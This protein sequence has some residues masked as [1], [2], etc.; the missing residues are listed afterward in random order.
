MKDLSLILNTPVKF[1]PPTGPDTEWPPVEEWQDQHWVWWIKGHNAYPF[2]T[3]YTD[4]Q[5]I[6]YLRRDRYTYGFGLAKRGSNRKEYFYLPNPVAVPFH[7]AKVPNILFGGAAG[8]SKSY[9]QRYDAYRHCAT[10]PEFKAIIMRRTMAELRRNHLDDARRECE[11]INHF[12]GEEMMEFRVNDAEIVFN[13]HGPGRQSKL[14]FGHCQHVGDEEQYLGDA[15]EAFY[16]DEMATFEQKQII[17]VSGRLRTKKRRIVPRMAGSSNPGGAHTSWLRDYFIDKPLATILDQNPKYKPEKYLFIQAM[18]WDNPY[19]MDPD[20]TY[21]TYEERL[22]AYDPERRLQLLLGDWDALSGQFFPEFN[23][24]KHVRKLPMPPGCRIERWIDWGY[25]PDYGICVWVCCL[26]NGRLHVFFEWKFNGA[27]SRQKYTVGEAAHKIKEYTTTFALPWAQAQ[28]ITRS[29]ADPSMWG[30]EQHIGE[31]YAET[32]A[33]NGVPLIKADS[34]R[35]MGWGRLRHWLRD[36]PDGLP[37]LTIDPECVNTV[38]SFT[39]AVRDGS[40]SDDVD[41]RCEDH[42]IDVCRYG[43]MSRPQPTR[44]VSQEQLVIDKIVREALQGQ[45]QTERGMGQIQ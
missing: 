4:Q 45:A 13:N 39:A 16:P 44:F 32:F 41:T 19:Y 34:D 10:I 7:A 35:V 30:S 31:D 18:L 3:H 20:G 14:V 29:I 43:V 5:I 8:G 25:D 28:R 15:Y 40:S 12:A 22:F 24:D 33:R 9:S 42:P 23:K 6:D 11:R 38:R 27:H 36:A 37:W 26:P 1:I 21:T 2:L 17:G